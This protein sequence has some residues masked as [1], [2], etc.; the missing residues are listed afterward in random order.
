M[1]QFFIQTLL[2]RIDSVMRYLPPRFNP[3]SFTIA[4]ALTAPGFVQAQTA[5][6]GLAA[7]EDGDGIVSKN[8]RFA[9]DQA[10]TLPSITVTASQI[11]ENA[12]GPVDG[13]I[14]KQGT[15]SAR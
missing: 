10:S 15:S 13:Y 14:A 1:R 2:F 11:P 8:A 6:S 12:Y 4:L 9:S 5:D 3:I 7:S